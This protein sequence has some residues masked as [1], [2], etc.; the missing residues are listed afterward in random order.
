M[1]ADVTK[2]NVYGAVV[3]NY[4]GVEI[5]KATWESAPI[6]ICCDAIDDEG[7]CCI[8]R[9]LYNTILQ[10]YGQDYMD[11]YIAKDEKFYK[12]S[13]WD[14]VDDFRWAEEESLFIKLGG[15]YNEDMED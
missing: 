7:M 2:T 5:D 10:E 12:S 6:P 9:T 4:K 11:K 15:K 14:N 1:K 13:E 8:V 3:F